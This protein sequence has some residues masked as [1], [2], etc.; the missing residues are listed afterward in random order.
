MDSTWIYKGHVCSI[1]L[2]FEEDNI[3]AFHHVKMPDGKM[4]FAPISPYDRSKRTVEMWIDAGYPAR[5]GI[6][7]WRYESLQKLLENNS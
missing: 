1:E 2:D 5:S 7:N 3:K 4:T 6:G